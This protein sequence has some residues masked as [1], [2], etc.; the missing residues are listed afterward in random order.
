MDIGWGK[1][2]SSSLNQNRDRFFMSLAHIVAGYSS[3]IRLKIGAVLTYD[4]NILSIGYNGVS[5]DTI[6]C[7]YEG[8]YV[9]PKMVSG[10]VYESGNTLC[11][12]QHAEQ[13]ALGAAPFTNG[14]TLCT[15]VSPCLDCTRLIIGARVKRVVYAHKWGSPLPEKEQQASNVTWEKF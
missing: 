1:I 12:G 10:L 11:V 4:G 13:V 7:A 15:T 5:D 9:C 14:T 2:P 8:K 6:P 3:C